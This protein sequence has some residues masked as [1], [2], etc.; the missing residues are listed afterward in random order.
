MLNNTSAIIMLN[1]WFKEFIQKGYY[2]KYWFYDCF[3]LRFIL[4][5]V[6]MLSDCVREILPALYEHVCFECSLFL[7]VCALEIKIYT[8]F[9]DC[10]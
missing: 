7:F 10:F 4:L 6:F 9:V 3:G 5:S 8:A 2:I 1:I